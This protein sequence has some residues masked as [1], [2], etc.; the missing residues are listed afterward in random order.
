MT[1][2]SISP[3]YENN[4]YQGWRV[5]IIW[6]QNNIA[7][8]WRYDSEGIFGFAEPKDAVIFLLKFGDANSPVDQ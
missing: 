2:V 8:R 1:F 3:T 6:C 4:V 5:P 7:N